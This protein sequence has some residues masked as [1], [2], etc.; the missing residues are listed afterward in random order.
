MQRVARLV[1]GLGVCL[2]IIGLP[3]LVSADELTVYAYRD[4][5]VRGEPKGLWAVIIRFNNPVFPSN[6]TEATKV[7]AGQVEEK[8][9]LRTLDDQAVATA[10]SREFR[11][12]PA[13][14]SDTPES[15]EVKISK[16]LTDAAGRRLLAKD[17]TYTFISMENIVVTNVT[18]F[19]RSPSEKGLKLTLSG[20]VSQK[21][22]A[23]AMQITPTVSGLAVYADGYLGWRVTGDFELDRDY[24]LKIEPLRVDG[25][26]AILVA[27]E[28]PFKGPGLRGDIGVR[29]ERSVVELRGRQLLPLTLS[30]VTKIRCKLTRIPPY[31]VPEVP[32]VLKDI[33]ITQDSAESRAKKVSSF[34]EPQWKEKVASF[35][36][37]ER[38]GK[39][40][41]VFAGEF[42]EDSDV[43]FAPEAQG[44]VRAY[45]L[46][47]TFRKNPDRGGMYI[48]AFTDADGKTA[49][50][51]A[52]LLQITDLAVSYKIS[53][54][55]L[56]IWVTHLYT[57]QPVQGAEILLAGSDGDR[58]FAG[59]TNDSGILMVKEGQALPAL[60]GLKDQA[61]P[62]NRP[63]EL[64]KLKWAIAATD[65]DA[66]AVELDSMRLKPFAVAQT[67]SLADRPE[68]SRGYVFTE[69]GV[70]KPGETV[71]FK[72]VARSYKDH[73]V[74]SPKGQKVKVEIVSPRDDVVY[75]KELTLG[76]FGS[77]SDS[78]QTKSFFPVG[79]YTIRIPSYRHEKGK[80]KP[81]S[82]RST[83]YGE[84]YE[85]DEG[86]DRQNDKAAKDA[87]AVST[88]FMVQEFKR[89]R[90]YAT[91]SLKKEERP[92]PSFI[93]VKRQ[94]ELLNVEVK[95]LYYVGGPVKH[96]RVRWKATLVPVTNKVEGLSGYFFGNEDD[97]TRFLESGESIL[98]GEG[99]LNLNIPLDARLLTGIYGV[100]VSATVLDIDGEPAT[101]VETYNPRPRFL[102]GI[103][104]HPWQVQ[105]GFA[106]PL[107]VVMVDSAGKKIPSGNLQASVMQKKGFYTQKRDDEGNFNY[108]W[109]DAW[110][111]TVT[112]QVPVVNGEGVFNLELNDSGD[113][114]VAF[115]Y[116]DKDSR[117]T[118]QT[119]F[120]VG[121]DQYDNWFRSRTR[122]EKDIR[123]DNE[124][125]LSVA[126]NEY[127]VGEQ[128]KVQFHTPRP[129]RKCLVTLERG[130]ILDYRVVDVKGT[131][132][133]YEFAPKEGWQPNLFVS[134]MA[135][136]GREGFPVYASQTD[137]DIPMVYFGYVD[138]SVRSDTQKLVLEI[139]PGVSDLKGRPG[140]KK[141]L[142]FRVIDPQGKGVS[143]E[144]AV[145][146]VDEA[147][148]ALTRFQ[149][150]DLATLTR[151]NLP[152]G[153]FSGDLRL[154]LV[155]QDLFRMFSTRPLT[156]GGLGMGEVN[157]S[158]RKDFRP[159]A[160][161]N[162]ALITDESGKAT[163]Q[164]Q[165][166][167]TT[168]AYRVYAVVC[169]RGSGFVSGQRNM[170]VTKEFFIEPSLPRF[171]IP[172]DRF[173]FP[174]VLQN[175]TG[176]AGE[177][178][179]KAT[180]SKNLKIDLPDAMAKLQPWSS[181]VLKGK[182]EIAGGADKG[183][184]TFS[185]VFGVKPNQF[186]DAI[187]LTV[188]VHSRYL[189]IHRTVLGDFTSTTEIA[190]KFPNVLKTI[191]SADRDPGDFKAV[192]AL[193]T[194]NWTKIA[195][196]LRYLLAYPYGCVEQTSSGII[197]LAG[198]RGLVKAGAVPGISSDQVDKFLRR[199]VDRLLSMQQAGG[200][201]S[202]W[203]GQLNA[204][205]WGTMYATFALSA[206][207]QAG[208]DVPQD[209]MNLAM[210]F[211][212]EN[213]FEEKAIDE[214]HSAKWAKEFAVF[215]LAVGKKLTKQELETFFKDYNSLNEQNKA[216]LLIAAK[217]I[218][219]L[220]D[221]KLAEM[222]NKLNPKIDPSRTSY[223][224][225]SYREVAICLMAATEIGHAAQKAD[226]WAGYLLRGLKPDG[227]WYSTAD[228]GWCLLAL[229]KYYALSKPGKAKT[230]HLTIDYGADKPA[231]AV[232][233]DASAFVELDGRKLVDGERIK[234]HSDSKDML[235]NYSLS[236]TYPDMATDPSELSQGFTLHKTMENLNGK[237]EFRLG[238]VIRVTLN[239]DIPPA[240]RSRYYDTYEYLALE[241]PVPAGIVPINSELKT[242]GVE[243]EKS[244]EESRR[245]NGW[246]MDFTP[247]YSEFRD[248][249]VR[250]FKN[251]AWSGQYRYSYLA[252]VV[253]EGDFWM[254]GSR[255]SLM[256]SPEVFG[257]TLGK[258][259]TILPAQK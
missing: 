50:E 246:G 103:A 1:V 56:L 66:C 30:N 209:R 68:A 126:K 235:I 70:Y 204:S 231:E 26:R 90:H 189:P 3:V 219:Y 218:G 25:G 251:R 188:P 259:V 110:M 249:G 81:T 86:V 31:L 172:G 178:A 21:D 111:K 64:A 232:V 213:L 250:V 10:P 48:A 104:N 168:T 120:K 242:E 157:P 63:L 61:G 80:Q 107:K 13:K 117:Y 127:R 76:D 62:T 71:H 136:A 233:S 141:T 234:I 108:L 58:F 79:T 59:K 253:A 29:T 38:T 41:S 199:G 85:E 239:I 129:V 15:V 257:R 17:F 77:C 240:S 67:K 135:P 174:I 211:L 190:L 52:K 83:R 87:G 19:Y 142:S 115:T 184:L 143:A 223:M 140:E 220:P 24:V 146:V 12:V 258:R 6:L 82:R 186:D 118:S 201:F 195:P 175:K 45:S 33:I 224:D 89:L 5:S 4:S 200:G 226:S 42:S 179:L 217:K 244:E 130:E 37:L 78:L 27:K 128:V 60:V 18:T 194:T 154:A 101:E 216:L 32:G 7:R 96:G 36:E 161:F 202:Y 256:Y 150:P 54:G 148:L 149:T 133:S 93:G 152:L 252:R 139:E 97:A 44:K 122:A 196:G 237:E 185:G 72:F 131:D 177:A 181:A 180:S 9:E 198:I 88:T 163:I 208:Y 92:D 49:K 51:A 162:P 23:N 197:P 73:K 214:Y 16:G 94:E 236:L 170:V 164:F 98:D 169:D 254:R 151:F 165:L 84:D 47:L 145:C 147:V 116:E 2:W 121:W 156:G 11:L 46:P 207:H 95:G 225:S 102:I 138:V 229:S 99:K 183:V 34:A 14:T 55:S 134:V 91:V 245:G 75:T 74:V 124:I 100:T 22:V 144:M 153:V 125:L 166:P 137:T 215:N 109:E 228:T 167:D 43:F 28:V 132:G 248:D 53:A 193:S 39:V 241:D 123:T 247:N 243:S 238:D 8:Y 222:V 155:S 173:M 227:K 65:K 191:S 176:D 206:A 158:L 205:W 105:T 203:P 159:V 255:I 106:T 192:L 171:F 160:Y 230:V 112:S 119:L 20:R 212:R 35:G 57:G 187:E 69:R 182:A 221:I 113:Y 40:K 114:L 210:K